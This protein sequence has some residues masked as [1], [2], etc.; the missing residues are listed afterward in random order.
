M[1]FCKLTSLLKTT[2]IHNPLPSD[3]QSAA[4]YLSTY[5]LIFHKESSQNE[6]RYYTTH[7]TAHLTGR[8]HLV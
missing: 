8:V 1:N 5:R 3:T 2:A 6:K 4:P 7:G